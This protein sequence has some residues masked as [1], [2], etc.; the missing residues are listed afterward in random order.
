MRCIEIE[1][2]KIKKKKNIVDVIMF[3]RSFL[4]SDEIWLSRNKILRQRKY[5][6]PHSPSIPGESFFS[7]FTGIR[8]KIPNLRLEKRFYDVPSNLSETKQK[9]GPG[10]K[11][12]CP[13]LISCAIYLANPLNMF[14]FTALSRLD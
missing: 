9:S 2:L 7:Y 5:N 8:K 11:E 14:C 1:I 4:S 10:E 13:V 6:G 3:D 12:I